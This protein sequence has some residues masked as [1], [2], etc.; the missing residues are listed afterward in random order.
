MRLA[1]NGALRNHMAR[2]LDVRAMAKGFGFGAVSAKKAPGYAP[3]SAYCT[4]NAQPESQPFVLL[5]L[6]IRAIQCAL[7]ALI[8][9]QSVPSAPPMAN[10]TS[11]PHPAPFSQPPHPLILLKIHP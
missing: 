1:T 4:Y 7:H 3:S 11:A 9:T 6:S 5:Y 10:F 8:A 2:F